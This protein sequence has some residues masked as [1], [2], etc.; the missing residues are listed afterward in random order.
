MPA[1][2]FQ[3]PVGRPPPAA[4]P[5]AQGLKADS[6]SHTGIAFSCTQSNS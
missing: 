5:L 3:R 1:A 6:F 4:R 2:F